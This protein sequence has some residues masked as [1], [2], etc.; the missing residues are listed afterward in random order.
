[1]VKGRCNCGEIEFSVEGKTSGVI[2]CHCSLCRRG[3]GGSG[4]ALIIA[5]EDQFTW[6]S[7][8]DAVT[9][10]QKPDTNWTTGFCRVCGSPAP[11]KKE[12]MTVMLINAGLLIDGGDSL[13]VERHI[14]VDSKADWDVI[15]DVGIQH[16]EGFPAS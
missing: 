16:S 7:G 9:S 3:Y 13:E 1:M 11:G 6:I 12:G 5:P 14:W 15:G 2:Q 4:V 8:Q 10:W